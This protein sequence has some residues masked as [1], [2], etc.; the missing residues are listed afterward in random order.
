MNFKFMITN[1][2]KNCTVTLI[3]QDYVKLYIHICYSYIYIY[4]YIIQKVFKHIKKIKINNKNLLL[5]T[6]WD[7]SGDMIAIIYS[8]NK[9]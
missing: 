6:T 8:S 3:D 4:I 1:I 7:V 5:I 9:Y 2:K